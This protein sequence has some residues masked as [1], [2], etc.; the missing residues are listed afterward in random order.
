MAIGVKNTLCSMFS[1]PNSSGDAV[2]RSRRSSSSRHV[3]HRVPA[4][5]EAGS[6]ETPTVK[7]SRRES[8]AK[9]HPALT[10]R[11]SSGST[12]AVPPL[13]RFQAFMHGLHSYIGR[14]ANVTAN[15][16]TRSTVSRIQTKSYITLFENDHSYDDVEKLDGIPLYRFRQE[17]TAIFSLNLQAIV[18][19]DSALDGASEGQGADTESYA[20]TESVV[21]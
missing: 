6:D 12:V 5:P 10:A 4:A 17:L 21:S 20:A 13:T 8:V 1:D 9:V 7:T 15:R 2:I 3:T 14:V 16:V 11:L 19:E 18:G